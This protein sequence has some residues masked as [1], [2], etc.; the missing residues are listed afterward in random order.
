MFWKTSHTQEEF[1]SV[2][3]RQRK[4][5]KS[6]GNDLQRAGKPR[7]VSTCKKEDMVTTFWPRLKETRQLFWQNI[8]V[9][10]KAVDLIANCDLSG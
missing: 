8:P 3:F 6:L 10:D 5:I 4:P 2:L 7:D 9:N 1:Y